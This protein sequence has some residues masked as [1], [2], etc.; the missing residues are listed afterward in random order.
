[1]KIGKI[2]LAAVVLC[3]AAS[4]SAKPRTQVV[5]HR[6]Y[7]K[8]EGSAQNSIASLEKAIG[9][10]CR[11]SET[12]LILTTDGVLVLHH[13]DAREQLGQ[14]ASEE[15]ASGHWRVLHLGV[16][17]KGVQVERA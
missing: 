3:S 11:G 10:G 12:D 6:G 13:G 8:T 5:A 1:M 2:V 9:I 7:W 17:T 4:L 15:L 16:D 14:L